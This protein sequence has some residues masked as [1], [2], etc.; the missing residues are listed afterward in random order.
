[1]KLSNQE[2]ET[3]IVFNEADSTAEVFTYNSRMQRTLAK[4]A[5]DRPGDAQHIKTNPE[6]GATYRIPKGW[7]KIKPPRSQSEAQKAASMKAIEKAR[8]SRSNTRRGD[9]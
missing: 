9:V 4:L 1:M 3:V 2:R 8:L 5:A 7:V 6:G